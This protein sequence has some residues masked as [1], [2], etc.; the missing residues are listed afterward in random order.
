MPTQA[1]FVILMAED[2]EHD[3]RAVERIW[4]K[5]AIR[6]PLFIVRDGAE[7]LAY[8]LRQPPFQ[9]PLK[10]PDPGVLLLDLNMPKVDGFEVLRK[11]KATPG[12]RRLP[13]VV[14]TTSGRDEDIRTAYDL[15]ANA[16]IT[17]PVGSEKLSKTMVALNLFW[18]MAELPA[19]ALHDHDG[20]AR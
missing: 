1:P 10:H 13:V 8:L 9:D 4:A 19:D 2:S 15:G 20:R 14:L 18:E 11:V 3:V 7:C 12:L 16:Y 17:K 6:N 5:A